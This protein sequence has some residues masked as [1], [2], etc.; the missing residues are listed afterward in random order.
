MIQSILALG[1][2]SASNLAWALLVLVLVVIVKVFLTQP[3]ANSRVPVAAPK[4]QRP[5]PVSEIV[6]VRLSE[7]VE[8]S[9]S[10]A[11]TIDAELVREIAAAA[12]ASPGDGT[13]ELKQVQE[14]RDFI[15]KYKA[16][17]DDPARL[18]DREKHDF[19][20]LLR[21]AVASPGSPLGRMYDFLLTFDMA[22]SHASISEILA[23][24]KAVGSSLD[25]FRSRD[26][27]FGAAIDA[28]RS[29]STAVAP[30]A[31]QLDED[32]QE[33]LENLRR[34]LVGAYKRL[35]KVDGDASNGA[36]A[37]E[38]QFLLHRWSAAL[39]FIRQEAD[40]GKNRPLFVISMPKGEGP[41]ELKTTSLSLNFL[42]EDTQ[43]TRGLMEITVIPRP[44]SNDLSYPG[45]ARHKIPFADHKAVVAFAFEAYIF[46]Q[47]DYDARPVVTFDITYV[48][49]GDHLRDEVDFTIPTLIPRPQIV[50][51][52]EEG[53][54]GRPLEGSSTLFVGRKTLM[55]ELSTQ[56]LAPKPQYFWIHGLARTGK[57]SVL[58]QLADNPKW[59]K[60]KYTPI[61]IH[62]QASQQPYAFFYNYYLILRDTLKDLLGTIITPDEAFIQK[63]LAPFWRPITELL[64]E[65]KARL[66]KSGH[67]IL[68]LVDEFQELA[69]WDDDARPERKV[70]KVWFQFP[71]FVKVLRDQY[72]SVA[73]VVMFG[74]YSLT[75]L[76]RKHHYWTQQLGGRVEVK[77][78][79]NLDPPEADELIERQFQKN[80]VPIAANILERIRTYTGCHAFLHVLMGYYIFQ[81]LTK[82]GVFRH[83]R[84]VSASDVDHAATLIPTDKMKFIWADPWIADTPAVR[85]F[86]AA[87]AQKSF[88]HGQDE[89]D[90]TVVGWYSAD[91]IRSHLRAFH[92]IEFSDKIMN[93]ET[94][95]G[96]FYAQSIIIRNSANGLFSLRY[97]LFALAGERDHLLERFL[98]EYKEKA[99]AA[100]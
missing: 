10:I 29:V 72:D 95:I 20:I 21:E 35:D 81:T 23:A 68:F 2:F 18:S 76:D 52:F 44:R 86:L 54:I 67:R 31:A 65:N 98:E 12:D 19:L 7:G 62:A 32:R 69:E 64:R 75:D 82:D 55:T 57:S 80:R 93:F 100:K 51:P 50:N 27:R 36:N 8:K 85:L 43:K 90:P 63:R 78:I 83:D 41:I 5:N 59:L 34:L 61:E 25:D 71:E 99:G 96:D 74:L 11:A 14:G 28:V 88:R 48:L 1:L 79:T 46:N 17:H 58:N 91:N 15:R 77:Q 22:I 6:A 66:E 94:V 30:L 73:T 47:V 37:V 4:Q 56:L 16:F 39:Q 40:S 97:P 3:V 24:F 9:I 38:Y 84:R 13:E 87:L 49:F 53:Q 60:E 45:E 42:I 26:S 70:D 33:A 89:H 92:G